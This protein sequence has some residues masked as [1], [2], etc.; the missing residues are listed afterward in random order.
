M[1]RPTL[2][3]TLMVAALRP[4]LDQLLLA[5]DAVRPEGHKVVVP[6]E[7]VAETRRVLAE[8]RRLS[9]RSAPA[10]LPDP[11][12]PVRRVDLGLLIVGAQDHLD[13]IAWY[14]HN[15]EPRKPHALS[16]F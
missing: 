16:S 13:R 7:I 6:E 3:D 1:T 10:R 14:F 5:L 2:H 12:S 15:V 4:Q 11:Q 9:A 8:I